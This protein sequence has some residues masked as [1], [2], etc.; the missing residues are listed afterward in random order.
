MERVPGHTHLYRHR[1]GRYYF[2]RRIPK[3]LLPA[4]PG[5]THLKQALGT[6]DLQEAKR[7]VRLR[8]TQADQEFA[9]A[10]KYANAQLVQE[11]TPE[12]IERIAAIWYA[13]LLEEDEEYRAEGLGDREFEKYGE[14]L[15]FL[16]PGEK[17]ALAKGD[18]GFIGDEVEDFL[19]SVGIL[20][21]PK[22]TESHRRLLFACLKEWVRAS[23]GIRQRHSGEIIDTPAA[24]LLL[25][26][27]SRTNRP[28]GIEAGNTISDLWD[29]WCREKE[30]SAKL[31]SDWNAS[32]R[33]FIEV[34][35]DLPIAAVT[36][37]SVLDFRDA[38]YEMPGRRGEKL[39]PATVRK[40]ITALSTMF[41]LAVQHG[42][43]DRSPFANIQIRDEGAPKGRESFTPEDLKAIFGTPLGTRDSDRWLPVLGLYTGARLEELGQLLVSD[44][45]EEDGIRFLD[46]NDEGEKQLKTPGSRRRVPL[47]PDLERIGFLQFHA[48]RLR[49]VGPEAPLF[50][51][52]RR[53]TRGKVTEAFSKRFG[54][55]LRAVGITDPDKVFHSFRHTFKRLGRASEVD[56]A[57]LDALQGHTPEHIGGRYGVGKGQEVYPL[58]VLAKA[59]R[60]IQFPAGI[61][62]G[63]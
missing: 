38:L 55:H 26:P 43:L 13:H 30:P 56:N 2:F 34:C 48:E 63:V 6:S 23:Q 47:H 40:Q 4:Y 60:A 45:R 10:R 57:I 42:Q 50:G 59:V 46:I 53:S 27:P 49:S 33:R 22:G 39:A 62:E 52:L 3:D 21:P 20:V 41:G 18:I 16:E 8:S 1:N 17:R 14:T 51:D 36:R 19:Q 5:R 11:L 28:N 7:L 61:D 32:V 15:E 9:Q 29:A 44:V 54:R 24:P 25:A 37:S 35:G 12:E 58:P 31:R